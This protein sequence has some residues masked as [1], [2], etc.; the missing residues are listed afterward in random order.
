[1]SKCEWEII[2]KGLKAPE[3]YL[4]DNPQDGA[5]MYQSRD[6]ILSVALYLKN[7]AY[8]E[9]QALSNK[10]IYC[11]I[12]RKDWFLLTLIRF[13]KTPIIFEITF[14]PTIYPESEWLERKDALEKNNM[15]IFLGID[16]SNGIVKTLRRANLP[17][18]LWI[19]WKECWEASYHIPH[20][21]REY[22]R[23]RNL[24]E[25]RRSIL[26][27]WDTAL[28]AGIFGERYKL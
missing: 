25:N 10:K 27:S 15:I 26:E 21:S 7:M 13:G 23:W 20:Y 16:T 1:M 2:Q 5:R 9:E 8:E 19:Q 6:N 24:I 17:E 28:E 11:R 18:K 12:H 14:D 3:K 22:G 4:K